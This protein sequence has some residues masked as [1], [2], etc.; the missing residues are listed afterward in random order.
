VIDHEKLDRRAA[1]SE[2]GTRCFVQFEWRIL[3]AMGPYALV[4]GPMYQS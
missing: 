3:A 1:T 2:F 4:A